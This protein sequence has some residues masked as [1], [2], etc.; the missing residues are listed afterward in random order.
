MGLKYFRPI[1]PT[2]PQTST[3]FILLLRVQI[4]RIK[5]P[6]L[7]TKFIFCVFSH[8]TAF[9]GI[10]PALSRKIFS[11]LYPHRAIRR[12]FY[13]Q[14]FFC[15]EILWMNARLIQSSFVR[16][17][18]RMENLKSSGKYIKKF[19]VISEKEEI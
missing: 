17:S 12:Q 11:L 9:R 10:F 6:Q 4:R 3:H 16:C 18:R 1:L 14:L 5:V 8:H 15:I 13:T 19:F 7:K 2:L